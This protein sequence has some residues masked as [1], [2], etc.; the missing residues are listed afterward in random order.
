MNPEPTELELSSAVTGLETPGQQCPP[1]GETGPTTADGCLLVGVGSNSGGNTF[2][3]AEIAVG[4]RPD[5]KSTTPSAA[6]NTIFLEASRKPEDKKKGSD[7]NKQFDPGRKGTKPPP[8]N[9]AV[10]VLLLFF[11]GG[12]LGHGMP[13]ACASCSSS[14]CTCLFVVYCSIRSGDH[15]SAS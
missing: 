7:E 6:L 9:A 8:W 2:S 15:F 4:T 10:M 1:N 3:S 11:L 13:V 5:S 14:V 12:T